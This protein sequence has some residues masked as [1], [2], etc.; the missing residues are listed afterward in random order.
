MPGVGRIGDKDS[1]GDIKIK[2]STDVFVNGKGVLRLGD[3]DDDG[4][5]DV[6]VKGSSTVFVN[7]KP[8]VR[9]GDKDNDNDVLVTA[10]ADV[11][12]G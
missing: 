4:S 12:A 7:G 9:L 5:P 10:S 8:V 2:G 6:N 11:I 3:T 1:D